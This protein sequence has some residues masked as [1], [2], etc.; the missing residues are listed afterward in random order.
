MTDLLRWGN[1]LSP[2]RPSFRAVAKRTP[3]VSR[4]ALDAVSP[5]LPLAHP[6][7]AAVVIITISTSTFCAVGYVHYTH[8]ASDERLAAQ[9]AERA[10]VDLQDALNR[11][12]DE[13]AAASSRTNTPGDNGKG[14]TAVSEQNKSELITQFTPGLEQPRDLQL[15]DPERSAW[16]IKLK[17]E[18]GS[19]GSLGQ[20]RVT[21]EQLSA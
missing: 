21:V 1:A 7:G 11:L 4:S 5:A 15:S 18:P 6:L 10:N 17:W 20:S 3:D 13:L 14:Q 9:R 12:R 8:A 2:N 19:Q 16:A